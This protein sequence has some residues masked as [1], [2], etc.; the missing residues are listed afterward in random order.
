[1]HK[2]A[3]EMG[4]KDLIQHLIESVEECVDSTGNESGPDLHV[5]ENATLI[6]HYFHHYFMINVLNHQAFKIYCLNRLS[7]KA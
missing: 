2:C 7:T 6:I 3:Q 5:C 4:V 1:M